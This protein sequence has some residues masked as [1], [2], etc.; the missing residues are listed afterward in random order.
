MVVLRG[1]Q[2]GG[3]RVCDRVAVG[4]QG[5][6]S[7][8]GVAVI[9]NASFRGCCERFHSKDHAVTDR[10]CITQDTLTGARTPTL[11]TELLTGG[12]LAATR[13]G[14]TPAGDNELDDTQITYPR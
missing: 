7:T 12:L 6:Q 2:V 1:C 9:A 5:I 10:P 13:P 8:M 11:W 4:T 14:L 3:S